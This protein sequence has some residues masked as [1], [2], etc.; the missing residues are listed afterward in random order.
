MEPPFARFSSFLSP[1]L[2]ERPTPNKRP[3]RFFEEGTSSVREY[4]ESTDES[5]QFRAHKCV[6]SRE[7][8]KEELYFIVVG[9]CRKCIYRLS[10]PNFIYTTRY[11]TENHYLRVWRKFAKGLSPSEIRGLWIF[12]WTDGCKAKGVV[13]AT[14]MYTYLNVA[15][16]LELMHYLV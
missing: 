9:T 4:Y 1:Y 16:D 5:T 13:T 12:R 7:S 14:T 2:D 15:F 6:P 8:C 10:F 3:F 11:H